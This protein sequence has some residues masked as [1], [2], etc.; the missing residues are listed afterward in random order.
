[1]LTVVGG[2][3]AAKTVAEPTLASRENTARRVTDIFE[4]ES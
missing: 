3:L 2:L 1:M 4:S